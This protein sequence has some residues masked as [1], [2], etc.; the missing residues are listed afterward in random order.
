M[1]AKLMLRPKTVNSLDRSSLPSR[2][3]LTVEEGRREADRERD[4][5]PPL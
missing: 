5:P 3:P 1:M 2:F 4:P